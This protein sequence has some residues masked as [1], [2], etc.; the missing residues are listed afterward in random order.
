MNGFEVFRNNRKIIRE[1]GMKVLT[2]TNVGGG[3]ETGNLF[4]V[5]YTRAGY[6]VR[7]AKCLR[8]IVEFLT[9]GM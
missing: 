4:G 1:Y 5:A 8:L 6:R 2:K 3:R 7:C 9:V